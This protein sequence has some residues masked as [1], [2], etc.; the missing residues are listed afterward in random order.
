MQ[1]LYALNLDRLSDSLAGVLNI[2]LNYSWLGTWDIKPVAG[3]QTNQQ[4]GEIEYPENRFELGFAYA[5]DRWT[6]DW[7]VSYIG[8]VVDGNKPDQDNADA[9][10]AGGLPKNANTCAARFYNNVQVGFDVTPTIQTFGGI[11][12]LLAEDPCILGQNTQ[13]GDTGINTNAS[14]YDVTG[15]NFYLG[16]R[17]RL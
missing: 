11:A 14:M 10:F 5:L 1:L 16:V 4:K 12:N 8:Q 15:R 2:N 17:A 13:Y 7:T 3:G 6:V 9:T